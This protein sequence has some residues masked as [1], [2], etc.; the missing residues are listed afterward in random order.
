MTLR[1]AA[2]RRSSYCTYLQSKLLGQLHLSRPQIFT[3]CVLRNWV[4]F[5]SPIRFVYNLAL[6]HWNISC[7]PCDSL[8]KVLPYILWRGEKSLAWMTSSLLGSFTIECMTS[9]EM[10]HRA[11]LCECHSAL[12]SLHFSDPVQRRPISLTKRRFTDYTPR[13]TIKNKEMTWRLDDFTS[14][15]NYELLPWHLK[16]SEVWIQLSLPFFPTHISHSDCFSNV[17]CTFLSVAGPYC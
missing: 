16:Q 5:Q 7:S 11:L 13:T 12:P 3:C 9:S 8:V 14:C 1:L 4:V 17:P 15:I 6:M 10:G 2:E